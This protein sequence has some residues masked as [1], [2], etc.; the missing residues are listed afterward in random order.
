[1]SSKAFVTPLYCLVLATAPAALGFQNIRLDGG[2]FP[3]GPKVLPDPF[4]DAV[5]RPTD[6]GADGDLQPALHAKPD[7]LGIHI[8]RWT[9]YTLSAIYD[10]AWADTGPF[11][12]VDVQFA[13][14]VNPPGPLNLTSGTYDP[15][16][17]GPNPVFGWI[18]LDV[19]SD[20]ST[21]GETTSPELRYL[22]N[23][24]RFGGKPFGPRFYD[25][26][27]LDGHDASQPFGVPPFVQRSG[28]EFHL[29][30]LGDH[31]TSF[32]PIQGN[33]DGI[34]QPGE[35]WLI[36]GPLFHRA[37]GF[38][39]FSTAAGPPPGAYMPQVELLWEWRPEFNGTQVSM[40]YP[41]LQSAAAALAGQAQQPLDGNPSNQSS[42]QEALANLVSSVVAIPPN[43]PLR[44]DPEFPIIAGWQFQQP[45]FFFEAR[46]WE[47][48]ALVGMAYAARSGDGALFAW[49]D[50]APNPLPGDLN[51]DGQIDAG[52]T[53]A[54]RT[55][56]LQHDGDPGMDTGPSFDGQVWL[57]NFASNF[58]ICDLNYDGIVSQQDVM[59]VPLPGD[60]DFDDD[61]DA[62]DAVIFV[63]LLT[64]GP[65]L[66][67]PGQ[68][69]TMVARADV[70]HDG[71]VNGGDIAPFV[72][73]WWA[74]P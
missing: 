62:Q 27:A 72:Q 5:I 24:A 9:P 32:L 38:E 15:Y 21:G 60:L 55:F 18:E 10:G 37:H 25:R 47:V 3:Y 44:L 17:Y 22:A 49:T 8:G 28:E 7:L 64:H 13:G 23:V 73:L 59:A 4:G 2:P 26:V 29:A 54:V 46:D 19:D 69:A 48:T 52:D 61:V 33:G 20:I 56:I 36:R 6:P 68:A 67:P 12:R 31:I 71:A 39:E 30:L 58:S 45:Q 34:F 11:V 43:D 14:L 41:I 42:I 53:T 1:M 74:G 65:G 70:N 35:R 57:P 51:G 50:V 63:N 16:R 40:V 66:F